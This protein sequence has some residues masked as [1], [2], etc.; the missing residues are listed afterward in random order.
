MTAVVSQTFRLFPDRGVLAGPGGKALLWTLLWPGTSALAW[1]DASKFE[2][3]FKIERSPDG[4]T[5]WT[6]IATVAEGVTVYSDTGRVADTTYHYRVRAYNDNGDSEYCASDSATT[7]TAHT[8]VDP[9]KDHVAVAFASRNAH[10]MPGTY[11]RYVY[12]GIGNRTSLDRHSGAGAGE[13]TPANALNQMTSRSDPG[14]IHVCGYAPAGH[15]VTVNG[16]PAH[17]DGPFYYA[18][19]SVDNSTGPAAQS[20]TVNEYAPYD[21]TPVKTRTFT[22]LVPAAGDD[23]SYDDRG[24]LLSDSIYDYEW[25]ALDRL[26]SVETN[27]DIPEA[28]RVKL[29]FEYDAGGRRTKK[30]VYVW[31][32]DDWAVDSVVKF[33]YDGWLLIAELNADDELLRSY[34]WGLDVSGGFDAAGGVGGL[35]AVRLHNPDTGAITDTYYVSR[36]DNG[37]VTALVDASDDTVAASYQYSPYGRLLTIDGNVGLTPANPTEINPFLFSTKYYDAGIGLYYYGYRYYDPSTGRWLNRDPIAEEGGRLI[38]E[39]VT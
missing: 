2:D 9:P 6:Q 30:T 13:S 14:V 22:R 27:D 20:V 21:P 36:D 11:F 34:V 29:E 24:N 5:G 10:A 12:D 23:R 7:L 8:P 33:V 37:N 28:Y 4:S 31:P 17:R 38:F 1:T 35:L 16:L 25:D 15:R 39:E 18:A 19:V 32:D 3:G 26:T